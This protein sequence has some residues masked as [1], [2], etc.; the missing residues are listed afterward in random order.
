[1]T[2][3]PP[4]DLTDLIW[5]FQAEPRWP[6]LE[7][8]SGPYSDASYEAELWPFTAAIFRLQRGNTWVEMEI[9]PDHDHVRLIMG[10][11]ND[12]L[13]DLELDSVR[14]VAV[15]KSSS[16]ERLRTDFRDH[17]LGKTLRLQTKPDIS[18]RWTADTEV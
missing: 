9:H 3:D 14:T 16:W 12:R 5:L 1:M 11:G 10:V 8:L 13:A 2:M 7:G 17:T 4:P 6:H 15:E 18:L